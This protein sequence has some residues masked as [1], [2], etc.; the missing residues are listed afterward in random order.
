MTQAHCY[1][2]DDD[3][4]FGKSLKRL[5]NAEGVPADCFA[6]AQSFL[7][8]IHPGQRGCAIVDIHM[9][10]V[11]G[12]SLMDKMREMRYVM[13]VIAITGQ[14]QADTRDLAL[15]RGAVGFLQKPFSAESLMELMEQN[16]NGAD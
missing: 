5:L 9:P 4:P 2:V 14:T 11:D 10:A 8:S 6:S 12:Y 15:K 1:I 13:P 7:D 16:A 3:L